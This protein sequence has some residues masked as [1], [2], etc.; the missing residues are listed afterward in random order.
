MKYLIYFVVGGKPDYV[1]LLEFCINTIKHCADNDVFDILVLCDKDY[2]KYIKHLPIEHI[3]VTEDNPTNERVST[4]KVEIFN[5]DKIWQYEKVLYL[6]C[7]IV[8]SGSLIEIM[9]DVI[10]KNKL[11]V[12]NEKLGK[13]YDANDNISQFFSRQDRPYTEQD[14]EFFRNND[15]YPF[16]AGEFAFCTS[17]E[18]KY[19]FNN[20]VSEIDKYY[21]TQY[22]FYEQCFMNDYFNRKNLTNNLLNKYCYLCAVG[23][24]ITDKKTINH[25]LNCQADYNTKLKYMQ[26]FH[27]HSSIPP[28]II[29]GR[30]ELHTVLQLSDNPV[31]A[32]IGVF[33]GD[34]AEYLL[35]YFKPKQ[36]FLI[37]PWENTPICSGDKNGNNVEY[38]NGEYLYQHVSNKYKT[39]QN[40]TIFKKASYELKDID[41]AFHML[42]MIYIDGDYSYNG[43]KRDLGIAKKWVKK[44][45]WICGH[46]Y[47]MN[48]EKTNNHYDFGVKKAVDEFCYEN[49][50]NIAYLAND[51]CVSYAIRK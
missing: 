13:D 3:H 41:I 23:V 43:V 29:D 2:V 7:D 35:Q 51:G 28:I 21:G 6:D 31:I 9:N 44:G 45:G 48:Y 19:H 34:Y 40:V 33:K 18:M 5:F 36:L 37:D 17:E 24:Y 26:E 16:N 38:F 30:E 15:I 10:N 8:I 49:G 46:D 12:C 20:I 14:I 11:Y 27:R 22:Y 25:F 42:D 39:N 4:R 1:R 50:Y 47:S 32:E